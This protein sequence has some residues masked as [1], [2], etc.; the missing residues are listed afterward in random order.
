MPTED[1]K[2][3]H[4]AKCL[5]KIV[6]G[7]HLLGGSACQHRAVDQHHM[8]TELRHAAEVMRRYQHYPTLISKA[9]HQ[10][11]DRFFGRHVDAG[12]RFVEQNNPAT[13]CERTGQKHTFFLTARKLADLPM[14]II[15]HTNALKCCGYFVMIFFLRAPEKTHVAVAPHH[16]NVFDEYREIPVHIF[17]LRYIRDRVAL[18]RPARGPAKYLHR[19]G[20]QWHETHDGLEQGRFT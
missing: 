20:R 8:I 6:E 18:Q 5:F 13:L 2:P 19:T 1:M 4:P 15:G 14:A 17:V 11:D 9:A 3:E 10:A 16:H 7:K 12:E